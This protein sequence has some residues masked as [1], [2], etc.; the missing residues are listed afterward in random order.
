MNI[1]N[2][3]YHYYLS[4][5][6]T[7][8]VSRYDTHKK[9]ELRSVCNNIVKINKESPLYKFQRDKRVPSFLIDIKENARQVKNVIS[10]LSDHGDGLANAF[11][12]KSL[13][14]LTKASSAQSM[15]A[16]PKTTLHPMILT[17][18]FGSWLPR[19]P[20]LAIFWRAVRWI[21]R[22]A[23]MPLIWIPRPI[24]LNFNIL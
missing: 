1:I 17:S 19:S 10:S 5:Y 23:I 22:Q 4:A 2:S 3:A 14:R 13:I 15:S 18:R 24:P 8:S 7:S 12:K 20:I 16:V 11:Q 6:G 9:S 21:L